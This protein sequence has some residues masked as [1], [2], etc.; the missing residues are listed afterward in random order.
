ML[1]QLLGLV[2]KYSLN[3]KILVS[4]SCAGCS[5]LVPYA[6]FLILIAA[7]HHY[8]YISLD[9]T[10]VS[11]DDFYLLWLTNTYWCMYTHIGVHEIWCFLY[12]FDVTDSEFYSPGYGREI[13]IPC[14]SIVIYIYIGM[15]TNAAHDAVDH[16][17]Y[18][19]ATMCRVRW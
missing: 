12:Q 15:Y 18:S 11:Y 8:R 19:R 10:V 1:R 2:K 14:I 9:R 3:V 16:T 4:L 17:T 13:I 5:V 7:C 6:A